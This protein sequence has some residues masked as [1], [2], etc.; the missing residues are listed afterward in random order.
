MTFKRKMFPKLMALFLAVVTALSMLP[1]TVLAQQEDPSYPVEETAAATE[2]VIP[3]ETLPV[4]QPKEEAEL[5]PDQVETVPPA[6]TTAAPEVETDSV[7][8]VTEPPQ[9][10]EPVLLPTEVE[11]Y[12]DFFAVL[13]AQQQDVQYRILTRDAAFSNP[14]IHAYTFEADPDIESI[15]FEIRLSGVDFVKESNVN[16]GAEVLITVHSRFLEAAHDSIRIFDISGDTWQP[17]TLD[18]FQADGEYASISFYTPS[19]NSRFAI[20]SLASDA[21]AFDVS[22]G[23]GLGG[24]TSMAVNNQGSWCVMGKNPYGFGNAS[25]GTFY[26]HLVRRP[27]TDPTGKKT[28]K[29]DFMAAGC[30]EYWKAAPNVTEGQVVNVNYGGDIGGWNSLSKAQRREIVGYLLYGVR[31]L[32]DGSFAHPGTPSI[33][34]TNPV[35]NMTYAQ[36]ILIWSTVKGIDPYDALNRY[37][38]DVPYYGEKII[39]LANENP[40]NYDYDK[41]LVLVGEGGSKQDL[42]LILKPEKIAPPSGDI[43]VDKTVT[44]SNKLN[45]WKMELYRSRSDAING[46]NP[47]ATAVTNKNGRAHF[48]EI[49]NGT[50]Y[51]REAPASRQN[52]D[53]TYWTLSE[54]VL[55]VVVNSNAVNAGTIH[56]TFTTEYSYG[57]HKSSACDASVQQQISGN[58]MYSLA[59]ARYKVTLNGQQQEILTTDAQGNAYG[60]RK[61]PAGTRLVIQ[62]I[63]APPG[64][65]LDPTEYPMLVTSGE[66]VLE[67]KDSPLFDPPFSITKIDKTTEKPQG[68]AS[69]SGAVFKWEYFDNLTWS[70]NPVRTWFFQTDANGICD[71]KDSCFAAGYPSD[72]LYVDESGKPDIPLGSV[73]M[74][75][76]KNSLGYIVLPTP[77]LCTVIADPGSVTGV[78]HEFTP[79]SLKYIK[80]FGSGNYGIYEPINTD[81]FGSIVLDKVDGETGSEAQGNLNLSAKFQV[82]NRS[83]NSV[84]IDSFP[85]AAPGEICYEFTT[86]E[87][88]HFRSGKIFPMGSY[89]VTEAEPPAGYVLN[90]DWVQEFTVTEAQ[91]D[92]D[93]SASSGL[94]CPDTPNLSGSISM[95]KLDAETGAGPQ[96]DGTL[97]SAEFELVNNSLHSISL[98]GVVAAPGE[99]L[100]TLITDSNGHLEYTGLPMGSYYLRESAAP[101][102][103]LLDSVWQ[104]DFDITADN[105]D[106][107]VEP[108]LTCEDFII[109]GGLQIIK[110]DSR[111]AEN[112]PETAPLDGI[113]FHVTNESRLPVI[114]DGISYAPGEVIATLPIAWDGQFWCAQTGTNLPYGT[115]G[116]T[117]VEMYPGMAN[118]Y[119]KVNPEKQIVQIRDRGPLVTVIHKNEL[120][121]GKIVVHKVD[122]LG[123][124]LAGAKFSLEW[125]GDNGA[126]WNPVTYSDSMTVGSCTS[127]NL[128]DG[129]LTTGD[130]G[131]ITFTG[132]YPTLMYRVTEV[133]A[134]EGYVLLSS[135]AFE[136]KLPA[137]EF[138]YE[139]TVHNSPGFTFPTTGT[140]ELYGCPIVGVSLICMALAFAAHLIVQKK[141]TIRIKS[142]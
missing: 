79:E 94:A 46:K 139:M 64:Y 25:T 15:G 110:Q 28:G 73:R 116:V 77:L 74:T 12:D 104:Y 51:L 22:Y 103:Y 43:V 33:G 90:R 131:L 136:G 5:P 109:K 17:L 112:T 59:G 54:Q 125:S 87:A 98:N 118:D 61:Y 142:R 4:T 30:L 71:Y 82:V 56:N 58:A 55:A 86:D 117:E 81:L 35:V 41:T 24:Y 48:T 47:I 96:G 137:Q 133:E 107:V 29:E 80:D 105:K 124:P 91:Q 115:Y 95:D 7:P 114:I 37:M 121:E 38:N 27:S 126:T 113:T 14:E 69:F 123:R 141:R 120:M 66:N 67:V 70:G 57:I 106:V 50:Y 130:D 52:G 44:G 1:G 97:E 76:V 42:A 140:T 83:A 45:G 122:P 20:M 75:E 129:M 23:T 13:H 78:K 49:L 88:G 102:G 10:S 19:V 60:T 89:A 119:Y 135:A 40:E 72:P 8:P 34:S 128:V 92:F 32:S 127:P 85:V 101:E 53:L 93:F 9:P 3:A 68:D 2:S 26:L 62:E 108:S 99:V 6:E 138:I 18:H 36:Q 63:E 111:L 11:Y 39:Q 16:P 84:Q 21:S 134:P 132:L 65:R 100:M 31:Y